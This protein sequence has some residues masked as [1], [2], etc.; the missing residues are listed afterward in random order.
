MLGRVRQTSIDGRYRLLDSLGRGGMGEVYLARDEVLDREV[1]VKV[2]AERYSQDGEAVERFKREARSAAALSHPNI[3]SVHD[4]G[5]TGGGAHY[6]VMEYV[7]CITNRKN[8]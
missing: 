3:V 2:L 8:Y 5:E 4:L 6:I 1:A 7:R